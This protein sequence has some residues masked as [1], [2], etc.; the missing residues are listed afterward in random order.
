VDIAA[1]ADWIHRNS[2]GTSLASTARVA[3]TSGIYQVSS[4]AYD[5]LGRDDRRYLLARLLQLFTPGIP[6][7]YYVGLLAGRNDTELAA[8]TGDGREINRRRYTEAEVAQAVTRP[9]VRALMRLIRFRNSH[10]A[11]DGE[12]S[13]PDAPAGVL[14][15]RWQAGD[16]QVDLDSRLAE[17][18][19]RLTYTTDARTRTVT[20]VA[21]LP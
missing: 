11:F 1:L 13:L 2:G 14:R 15:M 3:R 7:V 6:Q 8:H 9:V 16:T 12:F 21:D 5:A 19:Y 10:P 20:D 17:A 18:S 4:T